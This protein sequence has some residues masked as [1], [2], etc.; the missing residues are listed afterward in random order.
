MK[1]GIYLA[2]HPDRPDAFRLSVIES[3][4]VLG[5]AS[6]AEGDKPPKRNRHLLLSLTVRAWLEELTLTPVQPP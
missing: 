4:G 5:V 2:K 1:P 6:F 3:S